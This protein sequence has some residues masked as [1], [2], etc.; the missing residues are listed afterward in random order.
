MSEP[1]KK[2]GQQPESYQPKK[3]EMMRALEEAQGQGEVGEHEASQV[4][5]SSGGNTTLVSLE[6]VP[7]GPY[8]FIG[9]SVYY[10]QAGGPVVPYG[11][12]WENSK[13]IF[14]ALD[15]LKEYATGE[16]HNIALMTWDKYDEKKKLMGYTVGRFMRADTPVPA[17]LDFFDI[18]AMTVA[19]GW[20]RGTFGDMLDNAS[21]LTKD[22][23]AQQGK[24][25]G[26]SWEWV[27]ETYTKETVTDDNVVSTM[28]CYMGCKEIKKKR[29]GRKT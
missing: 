18:P 3:P 25:V 28:G 15:G 19:K 29:R 23:I 1:A 20:V 16:T 7:F 4:A 12:L 22:A 5:S 21:Q 27:T 26:T 2:P 13:W 10:A 17:G 11:W 24:Y 8:R 14:E 9:K 6:I